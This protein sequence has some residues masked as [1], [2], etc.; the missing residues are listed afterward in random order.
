MEARVCVTKIKLKVGVDV[1]EHLKK[2]QSWKTLGS[3][4]CQ[5]SILNF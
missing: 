4:F 5:N 3:E 2:K 1:D